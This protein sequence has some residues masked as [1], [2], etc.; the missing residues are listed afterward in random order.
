MTPEELKKK[1]KN[2]YMLSCIF[3]FVALWIVAS[4]SALAMSLSCFKK[5][6]TRAQ[7]A[8]GVTIFALFGPF[9]WL[10][11]LF[12]RNYCRSIIGK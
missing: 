2:P 6:G 5:S 4:I 10:Y 11:Y 8:F 12:N 1:F 7:H 3:A 9:Y